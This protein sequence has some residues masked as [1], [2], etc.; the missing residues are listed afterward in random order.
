MK[1]VISLLSAVVI[2]LSLCLSSLAS[3]PSSAA[4]NGAT[5]EEK[6]FNY[7][8]STM[9]LNI[10]AAC[11]IMA[12]MERESHFNPKAVGD[13]GTSYG[14]CQWHA[15]RKTSMINWCEENDLDHETLQAQ[16]KFMKYEMESGAYGT[17]YNNVRNVP[18]T[19]AGARKA[20]Y[21]WCVYYEKPANTESTAQS[22]GILAKDTYWPRYKSHKQSNEEKDP[23]EGL[24]K[25]QD[26]VTEYGTFCYTGGKTAAFVSDY[27]TTGSSS[28]LSIPDTVDIE[29]VT[30]KVTSIAAR[31]CT[32][33]ETLTV[34]EIGKN[35]TSIG[36]AAF[37]DCTNLREVTMYC[38]KV[39]SM[40]KNAFTDID[41][42]AVFYVKKSLRSSFRKAILKSAPSTVSVEK[43]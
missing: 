11:G 31:A 8:H 24:V 43:L 5:N 18:N 35:I 22:R 13:S 15:T 38:T 12:N 19:K 34:L 27:G 33:D 16:L 21:Y 30:L 25:D 42:D 6:V 20:A 36:R 1:R 4:L 23:E 10:A 2:A 14:I 28:V 39:P 26:Y 29:G 41:Q 7:L 3:F 17:A 37:M 32:M 9:G 40:G